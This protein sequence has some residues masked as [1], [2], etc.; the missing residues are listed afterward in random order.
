MHH[1]INRLVVLIGVL[2]FSL[3][4]QPRNIT[5]SAKGG[6][7]ATR[8]SRSA[9]AKRKFINLLLNGE[10]Y[11]SENYGS[12]EGPFRLHNGK[13]KPRASDWVSPDSSYVEATIML[14]PI[15]Y[16]FDH[17]DKD[18][19]LVL[20]G[21]NFGGSGYFISINIM[22]NKNGAPIFTATK[23]LG[24]RIEIDSITVVKDTI[25]VYSVVHGPN[26]P[27]A[28]VTMPY[29]FKLVFQNKSLAFVD[30]THSN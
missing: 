25:S 13:C 16:D 9:L 21:E 1:N 18:D 22:L 8:H 27:M 20:L 6:S 15:L 29:V 11:N 12:G 2:A 28:W 24:D 14:P 19:A 26:D 3:N 4:A 17:D 10:Y 5:L 7:S 30:G 23:T